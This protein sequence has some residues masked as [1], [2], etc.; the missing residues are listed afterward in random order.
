MVT[1]D[2]RDYMYLAYSADPKMKLNVGIRRRIDPL[3][4]HSLFFAE[5]FGLCSE[6]HV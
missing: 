6:F 2:E 1:V 3:S 4:V 5:K